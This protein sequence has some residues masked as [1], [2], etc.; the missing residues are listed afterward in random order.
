MGKIRRVTFKNMT[1]SGNIRIRRSI[2]LR[3]LEDLN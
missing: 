3:E 2:D 1:H